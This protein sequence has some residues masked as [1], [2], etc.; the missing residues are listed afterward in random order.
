MFRLFI[1]GTLR[2]DASA[3]HLLKG[4]FTQMTPARVAGKLY[5]RSFDNLPFITVPGKFILARGSR[6]YTKDFSAQSKVEVPTSYPETPP[7]A[8]VHGELYEFADYKTVMSFIDLYEDYTPGHESEYDRVL[9][10]VIPDG[11]EDY[12]TCWI[13]TIAGNHAEKEDVFVA[14]GLYDDA[15]MAPPEVDAGTSAEVDSETNNDEES[16]SESE[17]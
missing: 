17:D 16:S 2:S 4:K 11:S 15:T 10:P 7:S 9:Y 8:F 5:L 3:H 13:Y 1:Y 6:D 12:L 14:T